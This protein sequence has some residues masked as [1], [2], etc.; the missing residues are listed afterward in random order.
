MEPRLAPI[1]PPF[2]RAVATLIADLDER[3]LLDSTL[4]IVMGEFGRAPKLSC[5]RGG[6]D[7]VPGRDHWIKLMSVLVAGGG[8]PRGQVIGSSTSQGEEPI[9]RPVRR[10]PGT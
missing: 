3:G 5:F 9:D 6:D 2:D 1:L 7:P 8:V 10:A 4:V